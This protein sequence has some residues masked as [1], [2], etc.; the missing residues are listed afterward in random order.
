MENKKEYLITSLWINQKEG[1]I[2]IYVNILERK[3]I[4]L[5]KEKI[6]L[7]NTTQWHTFSRKEHDL[8]D[9]KQNFEKICNDV[10]KEMKENLVL[11]EGIRAFLT[12][13]TQIEI[14]DE[15]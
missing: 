3:L 12:D 14:K 6:K 11:V 10:Y 8:G 13:V 9:E 5:G 7:E 4:F 15:N 1:K 2:E